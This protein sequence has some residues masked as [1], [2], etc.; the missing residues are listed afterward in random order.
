MESNFHT[1]SENTVH[2]RGNNN[3]A[4]FIILTADIQEQNINIQMIQQPTSSENVQFIAFITPK[5]ITSGF[6]FRYHSIT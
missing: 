1:R 3:N 6:Q 4:S 2:D 5:E